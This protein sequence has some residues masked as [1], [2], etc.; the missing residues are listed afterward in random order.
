MIF[1]A[2]PG[3]AKVLL[4]IRVLNQVGA[5]AFAFLAVVAGPHLVTA[6]LT[7]FGLTALVSRWAGSCSTARP[8]VRSSPS[9]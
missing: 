9:A 8:R 6:A 5:F 3:P 4:A 2:L 1:G 7:V